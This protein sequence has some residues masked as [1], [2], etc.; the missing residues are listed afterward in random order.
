MV[1]IILLQMLPTD[2]STVW[3]SSG[4]WRSSELASLNRDFT[5]NHT[6]THTHT[7]L[8]RTVRSLQHCTNSFTLCNVR[9]LNLSPEN[10][11]ISFADRR[12]YVIMSLPRPTRSLQLSDNTMQWKRCIAASDVKF[13][14][15]SWREIFHE[16]FCE[17]FLKYFKKFHNVFFGQHTRPFN[18]FHMSSITFYAWIA[19]CISYLLHIF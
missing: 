17:I 13:H 3:R 9:N 14:E 16:I 10:K 5:H 19:L 4:V 11:L 2:R 12:G 6:H 8:S 18:I 1:L 7:Q 15:I